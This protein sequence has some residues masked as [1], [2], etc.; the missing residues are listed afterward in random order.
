MVTLVEGIEFSERGV[1]RGDVERA[2]LISVSG[3]ISG[4]I[5]GLCLAESI[6][7]VIKELD[8]RKVFLGRRK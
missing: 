6:V 5:V 2:P 3:G 4:L 8:L 7:G 1:V